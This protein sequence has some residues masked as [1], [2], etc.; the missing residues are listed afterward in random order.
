MLSIF[1][2]SIALPMVVRRSYS[3]YEIAYFW[4]LGGTLQ[5]V[6]TPD[7]QHGFPSLVYVNFFLGHGLVIQCRFSFSGMANLLGHDG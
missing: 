6:L 5:A 1:C 3:G 7:L 2:A 4:G